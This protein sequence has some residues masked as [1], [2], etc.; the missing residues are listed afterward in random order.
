MLQNLTKSLSKFI[1]VTLLM[2]GLLIG[3]SCSRV[4][5]NYVGVFMENYGKNGKSDF[6]LQTG[7]VWTAGFGTQLYHVPLYEQRGIIDEP[8]QIK[9]GDNTEFTVSPKYSYKVI[10]DKAIDV[11]FENRHA[12]T[13]SGGFFDGVEDNILE[14]RMYDLIREES[15]KYTT[16]E[17]MSNGGSLKF[18]KA[19]EVIIKEEFMKRGIELMTLSL[20]IEFSQTVRSKIDN[21]NEVN[22]NLSVLDQ[23]IEEQ[24]KRNELEKLKTEQLMIRSQGIS[25]KILMENFINKWDGKTPIY[26]NIPQLIKMTN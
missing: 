9:A 6:S 10:R 2:A 19:V 16:D 14:P 17:L 8:V 12:I 5:P 22:I 25:E 18:E 23:Q 15:R 11:V 13:G 7:T 3:T 24:K 4:E 1:Q 20:Q 26:G 21:R